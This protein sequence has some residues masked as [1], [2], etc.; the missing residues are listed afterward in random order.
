[1]PFDSILF[2]SIT[3]YSTSLR[4]A[5]NLHAPLPKTPSHPTYHQYAHDFTNALQY[6]RSA[7]LPQSKSEAL[8]PKVTMRMY[9]RGLR[10][11]HWH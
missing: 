6:P 2:H 4:A 7:I 11:L 3:F 10:I 5:V 1:M 9:I 8:I